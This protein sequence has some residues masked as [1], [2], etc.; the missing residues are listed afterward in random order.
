MRPRLALALVLAGC[1]PAHGGVVLPHP[2]PVVFET[3]VYPIL[4][5]DCAFGG[6]HG[7]P[8]RFFR[9]HGP[10]RTRLDP[11][12][13]PYAPATAEEIALAYTRAVSMLVDDRGARSSLLLRKPL[14]VAAGGAGHRGEDAWGANLYLTKQDPRWQTLFFWG[15]GAP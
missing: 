3:T 8:A 4:L 15:T 11:A 10:G 6:C 2:D 7:D 1:T 14:A 12:T 9:V 5:A 13:A